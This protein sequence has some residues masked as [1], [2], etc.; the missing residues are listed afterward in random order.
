VVNQK[1][2]EESVLC[3]ASVE[4]STPHIL[5]LFTERRA[6]ECAFQSGFTLGGRQTVWSLQVPERNWGPGPHLCPLALCLCAVFGLFLYGALQLHF[7]KAFPQRQASYHYRCFGFYLN[8]LFFFPKASWA[9]LLLCW[10]HHSAREVLQ[11]LRDSLSAPP[12]PSLPPS[13][14]P[15]FLFFITLIFFHSHFFFPLWLCPTPRPGDRL[16]MSLAGIFQLLMSYPSWL[17]S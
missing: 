3:R 15:P 8:I 16:A 9:S 14:P 11:S 17:S 4:L 1:L 6:G 10:T 2:G 13:L 7:I 5:W 12:S